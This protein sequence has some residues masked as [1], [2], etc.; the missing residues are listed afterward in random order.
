MNCLDICS[1][2]CIFKGGRAGNETLDK[3][4]NCKVC[5]KWRVLLNYFHFDALLH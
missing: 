3:T 2:L 4:A 5:K 1:N